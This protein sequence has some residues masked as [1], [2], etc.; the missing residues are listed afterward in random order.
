LFAA[1]NYNNARYGSFPNAPCGNGQTAAQGCNQLPSDT[2]HLYTAQDL[3]GR[4]LVNAPKW[5]ANFNVD[6]D[7]PIGKDLTLALG[8]DV[9]YKSSYSTVLID[10]PGF[11]Q[12]AYSMF[13]ANA[14]LKGRNDSWEVGL[15]GKNLANKYVASWCTNSNL[16]NATV[17]GGQI[18]GAPGPGY[19]GPIQ[20]PAGADEGACSVQRGREVWLRITVRP[21]EFMN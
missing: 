4:R 16:Q 15:V 12:R 11:E 7:M 3:S 8:G 6:Y 21:L 14:V 2:T 10:M 1:V 19:T 18:S 13:G 17:L 9:S 5:S 20:G